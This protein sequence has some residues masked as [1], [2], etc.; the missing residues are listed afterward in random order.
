MAGKTCR[1]VSCDG[2]PISAFIDQKAGPYVYIFYR[3]STV[4]IEVLLCILHNFAFIYCVFHFYCIYMYYL[5]LH[6]NKKK[7]SIPPT[8]NIEPMFACWVSKPIRHET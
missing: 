5:L 6:P 8:R 3:G 4:Y 1:P 7:T 2:A